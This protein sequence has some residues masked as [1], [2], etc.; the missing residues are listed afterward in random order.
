[1]TNL[2]TALEPMQGKKENPNRIINLNF[3]YCYL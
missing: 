1:M 2:A 3:K